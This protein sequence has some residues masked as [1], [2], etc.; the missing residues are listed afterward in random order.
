[1]LGSFYLGPHPLPESRRGRRVA[2]CRVAHQLTYELLRVEGAGVHP[3]GVPADVQADLARLWLPG[4][5]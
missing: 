5:R 4:P 2:H 3:S 1:M